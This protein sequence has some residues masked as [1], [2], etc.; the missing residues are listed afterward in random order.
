MLLGL[1]ENPALRAGLYARLVASGDEE[2][3]F[4]LADRERLA[5]SQVEHLLAVGGPGLTWFLVRGGL[6]P[7]LEIPQEHP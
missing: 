4:T 2:V 6:L 7:W 1:A 3:L 5:P